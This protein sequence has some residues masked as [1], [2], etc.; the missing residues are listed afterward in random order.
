MISERQSEDMQNRWD[1][2]FQK[3]E[4]NNYMSHIISYIITW[5]NGSGKWTVVKYL[6]ENTGGSIYRISDIAKQILEAFDIGASR[7]N[8]GKLSELLRQSFWED[9]Y[10]RAVALFLAEKDSWTFIFDWPRRLSV[11]ETIRGYG[12]TQ[13]IWIETPVMTRYERIRLRE[14]KFGESTLSYEEFLS[15]EDDQL[16]SIRDRADIIIENDGTREELLMKLAA[17]I[18]VGKRWEFVG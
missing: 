15:Q 16:T 10:A 11:I 9:I 3:S 13:I 18:H 1:T 4:S 5:T 7:E 12:I 8:I 14:E 2:F 17:I 6:A